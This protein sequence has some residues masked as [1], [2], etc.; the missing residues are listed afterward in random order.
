VLQAETAAQVRRLFTEEVVLLLH[1]VDCEILRLYYLEETFCQAPGGKE[2]RW[3]DLAI[4]DH[5]GMPLNTVTSRRFRALKR[6]KRH[7]Y[8]AARLAELLDFDEIPGAHAQ[9][10]GSSGQHIG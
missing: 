6:I 9:D 1:A 7:K 3:T 8:L 10:S 4:G 2:Q 5:L